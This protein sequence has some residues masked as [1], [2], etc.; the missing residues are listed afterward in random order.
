MHYRLK[1]VQAPLDRLLDTLCHTVTVVTTA[2]A[3]C[4]QMICMMEHT[5]METYE[6]NGWLA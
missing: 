3:I 5:I 4:L 6:G 2:M 1:E